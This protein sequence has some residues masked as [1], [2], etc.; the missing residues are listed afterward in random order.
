MKVGD[1]VSCDDFVN[2]GIVIEP[3]MTGLWM[4]LID[5]VVYELL[6]RSLEVVSESR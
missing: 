3:S 6:E 2:I 4:V 1:L 5:N